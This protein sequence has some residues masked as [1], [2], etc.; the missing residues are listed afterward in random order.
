MVNIFAKLWFIIDLDALRND[1]A[2]D[3]VPELDIG[4]PT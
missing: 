4:D 1:A 2:G 3:R